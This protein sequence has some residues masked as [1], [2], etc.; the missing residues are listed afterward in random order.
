[1]K[2]MLFPVYV[3]LA[4]LGCGENDGDLPDCLDCIITVYGKCG[5]WAYDKSTEGCC[6]NKE[7][8]LTE[9][10]TRTPRHPKH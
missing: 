4:V 1:M 3:V 9:T 8:Y 5:E 2:K 10:S 6:N 7:I